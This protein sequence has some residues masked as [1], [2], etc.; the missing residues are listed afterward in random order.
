MPSYWLSNNNF[1]KALG[2]R[3]GMAYCNSVFKNLRG[4]PDTKDEYIR[5]NDLYYGKFSRAR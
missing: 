1:Q 2:A 5:F 3:K 4:T